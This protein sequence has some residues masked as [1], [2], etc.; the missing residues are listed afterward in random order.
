MCTQYPHFF[1]VWEMLWVSLKLMF[2]RKIIGSKVARYPTWTEVHSIKSG[3]ITVLSVRM[4]FW[5]FFNYI[6]KVERIYPCQMYIC[7][8]HPH[9]ILS[10]LD[11]I[12]PYNL[13]SAVEDLFD[14]DIAVTL[15]LLGGVVGVPLKKIKTRQEDECCTIQKKHLSYNLLLKGSMSAAYQI[16][17]LYPNSILNDTQFYSIL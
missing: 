1:F 13:F 14:T 10:N 15:M 3:S 8:E 16:W 11:W 2:G 12:W 17:I 5:K 4:I 7:V 9:P 6:N